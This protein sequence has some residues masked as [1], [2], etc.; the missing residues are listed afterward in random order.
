MNKATLDLED[1]EYV[2]NL[3]QNLYLE[4][5]SLREKLWEIQKWDCATIELYYKMYK[6][7]Q[8]LWYD[9]RAKNSLLRRDAETG[10]LP[11]RDGSTAQVWPPEKAAIFREN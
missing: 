9:E 5:E 11:C 2:R 1:W 3:V 4:N 8:E 10:A 7:Y 6:K